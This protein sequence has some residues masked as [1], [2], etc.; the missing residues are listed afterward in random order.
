MLARPL[1]T[2]SLVVLVTSLTFS[3]Q[4]QAE[5]WP[6]WRGPRGDGSSL[7]TGVPTEWDGVEGKNIAWKTAIAGSG[8][9]SPIVWG[10]RVFVASC[11]PETKE[12]V[13]V[14]LDRKS[15]ALLWQKAVFTANLEGK[16]SLNSYASGT[17]ATDGETV[18]VSFLAPDT[19]EKLG[20]RERNPGDLV[21]AAYDFSGNQKWLARPGRFASVHGFCSS[22]V[23]FENLV[24]IN[25]DHD[26]ES[27]LAGLDKTT[28]KTVWKTLREHRTRSYC[29]PIVREIDGRTQMLLSGSKCVASYDP[30]TGAKHWEMAGPTEQFVASCV[31]DGSLLYLTAGFPEKH[32]LAVDPTG[33]GKLG[34]ESIKWRTTKGCS[35]VPSP[36]LSGDYLLV[37][38]DV[39]T[40]V[41]FHARTGEQL[42]LE[43][44]GKH[45]SAS[46]VAAGG[47]VYFLADDDI[48]KVVRPG[49]KL[50]VVAE[51]KLG[52]YC[53]ASPAISRG[54]LFLRGE[55]NL[56]CIGAAQ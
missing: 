25:G 48:T 52:E 38:A 13:L 18:Y 3:A 7:E 36:V 30:R 12:R 45:Y 5:D 32:I 49:A 9:S 42:W 2:L 27:Y 34:D 8:H 33:K 40:G 53:Y 15:G 16:H 54:Q 11:L 21:V 37:A 51:N 35:Y 56:Y 39:G 43:R 1:W 4:A 55:K 20:N 31:Y 50:E 23:L 19:S 22:P 24:L 17:P 29:T 44:M 41:C 10:D 6:G 28:G 46:L 14:A 26:G 47:L